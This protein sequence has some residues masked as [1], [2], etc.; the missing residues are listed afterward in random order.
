[1]KAHVLIREAPWYRRQAFVSG[2]KAAGCE[3]QTAPPTHPGSETLL[4]IWNRYGAMHELAKRV[5][6]AGGRVLVAENGYIG[7]GGTSPKFDVHPGGPKPGHYYALA[8]D[9][10]NGGGA[11]PEGGP[12]R[13]DRLGVELKPWRTAGSH[14]LVLPNRAFGVPGRMM[15]ANWASTAE[16]RFARLSG[17]PVRVR[18]HPGNKAP[19]RPLSRDLE[20]AWAA[21]VWTSGAGVQA[22]VAGV[23]VFCDAPFWVCKAAASQG[24]PDDPTLPDRLPA[25]HRLAWAQWTVAEIES[26]EPFVRLFEHAK[27]VSAAGQREVAASP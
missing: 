2:L 27:S 12:E 26:G 8:W 5:E 18:A 7:S 3:V 21:A 22:L 20:G 9:Y 24:S 14:L 11:W 23:P 1:M 25:L 13:W 17:R 6:A 15:P 4:V 19:Q 16:K 10:H